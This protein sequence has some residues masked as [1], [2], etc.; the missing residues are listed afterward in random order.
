MSLAVEEKAVSQEEKE[1]EEAIRLSQQEYKK[2]EEKRVE[3]S[4]KEE[5]PEIKHSLLGALPPLVLGTSK[6]NRP[7]EEFKEEENR[8]KNEIHDLKKKEE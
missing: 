7:I 8:L 5:K 6:A 4:K 3:E 2:E 1:F